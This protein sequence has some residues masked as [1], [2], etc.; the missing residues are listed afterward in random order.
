MKTTRIDYKQLTDLIIKNLKRIFDVLGIEYEERA[1]SYTIACP[2]HKSENLDSLSIYKNNGFFTCWS[3]RCELK[4]NT[5]FE[6]IKFISGKTHEEAL[7]FIEEISNQKVGVVE[8]S[9]D[10]DYNKMLDNS[11]YE[12]KMRPLC[13]TELYYQKMKI[14]AE[15][16]L[17]RGFS[18]DTLYEFGVGICLVKNHEMY[19]RAVVPVFDETKSN[20]LGYAGRSLNDKCDMCGKYHYTNKLCPSNKREARWASKWI[21]S[22]SLN[23]GAYLYNY[24]NAT[25]NVTNSLIVVEG[26]GDIWRLHEAGIKNA[27]GLFGCELTKRHSEL[28]E[29]LG[30]YRLHIALDNDEAGVEAKL[31]I[32]DKYS[33]MFDI[34]LV[35]YGEKDI[36]DMKVE[37]AKKIFGDLK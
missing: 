31:K 15:Y 18:F 12:T 5:V 28:M 29:R 36:G 7:L 23:T 21:N 32:I 14:P 24:W 25:N 10:I 11:E 35:D 22:S 13:S 17:K 1:N 19:L 26:Q 20:V 30:V 2:L 34:N 3:H 6:L 27:V 33:K 37:E 9:L 16:Y 8:K 4:Y